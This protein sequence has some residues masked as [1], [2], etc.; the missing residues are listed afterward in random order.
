MIPDVVHAT[1]RCCWCQ[2][3]LRRHDA[4]WWCP[5]PACSARQRAHAVGVPGKKGTIARWLY[6]PTPKQVVFDAEPARNILFG[7]AAGCSKTH[8]ARWRMH[9][10]ALRLP[11][12]EGLIVR[13]T[14]PELEK[15]HLRDM[16]TEAPLL[17]ATFIESKRLFKFPNGSLIE[18]GHLDDPAALR[19]YLSTEYDDITV[20]EGVQLQPDVLLELS[21]RARTSKAAVKAAGGAHFVVVTN[22]GGPANGMLLDFFIDHTP[23][24]D[25]YPALRTAYDPAQWVFIP[26]LLDDNP[27]L[28]PQY[29]QDLAVLSSWRYDQLRWGNFRVFA[30]QFFSTFNERRHVVDLG[31]PTGARWFR[32]MDWGHNQ[33]GCW[34]WWA[35]LPDHRLYIRR[36]YK[37]Q[38][39]LVSHNATLVK[40]MT[41]ELIG[42][43]RV[44]YDVGDPSIWIKAGQN[45]SHYVGQSIGESF[46]L[47]GIAIGRADN[48]RYNGWMCVQELLRDASDGTPWLVMHPDARYLMRSFAAAV[49]DPKDPDD[50]NTASDDHGLDMV[51]YGA[52]SR[53]SPTATSTAVHYPPGTMGYERQRTTRTRRRLGSESVHG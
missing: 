22:P 14:F 2:A 12:Y 11:G 6:L 5:T 27:Y 50:V 51:R 36:D 42:D 41:R 52:M 8:G 19:R 7:G 1:A 37:F 20:D 40:R 16:V 28:D 21:T 25:R 17:G 33:P 30:G 13:E 44:S 26:A 46:G 9:R 38:G 24:L 3:P 48:D 53:P 43:Q 35:I 31:T 10:R 34:G 15:T 45:T 39:E 23:D 47:A 18:C 32:S 29:E 4:L 49:S